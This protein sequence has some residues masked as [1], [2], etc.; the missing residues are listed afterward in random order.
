MGS[1]AKKKKC[2]RKGPKTGLTTIWGQGYTTFEE[3]IQ[4]GN[5]KITQASMYDFS[6]NV[7]GKTQYSDS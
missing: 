5:V 3:V 4:E 2:S 6:Q 1:P 7:L